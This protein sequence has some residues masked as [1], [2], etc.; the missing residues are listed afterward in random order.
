MPRA[1]YCS[2]RGARSWRGDCPAPVPLRAV[3][4]EPVTKLG[5]TVVAN[6]RFDGLPVSAIGANPLAAGADREDALQDRHLRLG[7]RQLLFTLAQSGSPGGDHFIEGEGDDLE[8]VAPAE[9]E[10]SRHVATRE[11]HA[12][13]HQ[14][15]KWT[16]ERSA[17][18]QIQQSADREQQN[19]EEGHLVPEFPPDGGVGELQPHFHRSSGNNV[20]AWSSLWSAK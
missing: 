19:E 7:V 14:S 1:P 4:A 20:A 12:G 17:G 9:V 5:G 6:V 16:H 15:L 2:I 11:L 3:R 13:V 10:G 18:E 8:L